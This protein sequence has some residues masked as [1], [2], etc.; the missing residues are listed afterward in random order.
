MT[1]IVLA[2]NDKIFIICFSVKVYGIIVI[3]III[4]ILL[5]RIDR[6]VIIFNVYLAY[7]YITAVIIYF[8]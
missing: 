8:L 2:V 5:Y 7:E 6:L 3:R 1:L 4:D